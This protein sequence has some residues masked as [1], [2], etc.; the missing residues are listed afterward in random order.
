MAAREIPGGEKRRK[1]L[2]RKG[3]SLGLCLTGL[4]SLGFVIVII[5]KSWFEFRIEIKVFNI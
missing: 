3:R 4:P 2:D 1:V 5:Y